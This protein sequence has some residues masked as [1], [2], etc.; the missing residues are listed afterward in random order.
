MFVDWILNCNL[1]NQYI[2]INYYFS[3]LNWFE[4]LSFGYYLYRSTV[5][6]TSTVG[7][8]PTLT[9]YTPCVVLYCMY[10][11][12]YLLTYLITYCTKLTYLV[13]YCICNCDWVIL[14]R[15]NMY[16]CHVHV[17]YVF[18]I[19]YYIN[20][21]YGCNHIYIYCILYTVYCII[22]YQVL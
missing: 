4:S 3:I 15:Y 9:K 5:D 21:V 20:I 6:S 13:V 12:T 1:I 2:H 22:I 10:L 14:Y 18:D 16:V 11:L 17:Q 8:I 19:E 7:V